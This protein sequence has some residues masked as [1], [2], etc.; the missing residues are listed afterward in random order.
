MRSITN[1]HIF[2]K[3]IMRRE[4]F[5]YSLGQSL[6]KKNISFSL[7]FL[8]Q[9]YI[10]W[11]RYYEGQKIHMDRL[12]QNGMNSVPWRHPLCWCS[13]SP[14]LLSAWRVHIN[15]PKNHVFYGVPTTLFQEHLE[16]VKIIV[17]SLGNWHKDKSTVVIF[18]R[19]SLKSYI[20]MPPKNLSLSRNSLKQLESR[21][22]HHI[23]RIPA[24]A[25]CHHKHSGQRQ[26]LNL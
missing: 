1:H 24:C 22:R 17:M 10:L 12:S 19:V 3:I 8:W 9:S 26:G 4:R 18:E 15:H 7:P 13:Y 21:E 16:N 2:F 20:R 6:W 23:T 14:F 11:K 25:A 5:I